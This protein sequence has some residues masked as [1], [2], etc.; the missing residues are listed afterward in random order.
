MKFRKFGTD[1]E[2]DE[3]LI[4]ES[5]EEIRS[6]LNRYFS[7]SREAFDLK[8]SFP[9]SFT[10]DVMLEMAKIPYGALPLEPNM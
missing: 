9:D 4:A 1:F 3:G 10:D 2:I 6:Q 7:G 5:E 8:I